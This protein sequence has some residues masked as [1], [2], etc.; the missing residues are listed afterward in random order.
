MNEKAG[1]GKQWA[2]IKGCEGGS[3]DDGEPTAGRVGDKVTGGDFHRQSGRAEVRRE[4][5][6]ENMDVVLQVAEY[7]ILSVW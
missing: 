2:T 1:R 3:A 7:I 6:E 4:M 5:G